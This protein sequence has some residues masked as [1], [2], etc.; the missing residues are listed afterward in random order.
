MPEIVKQYEI[1]DLSQSDINITAHEVLSEMGIQ[2]MNSKEISSKPL[3]VATEGI[4]PSAWGWGG[5]KIGYEVL[6][7]ETGTQLLLKGYIAQL[8][9][10]PLMKKMDEFLSLLSSKLSSKYN[11]TQQFEKVTS[12][13]PKMKLK[14]SDLTIILIL[15]S[16]I[17][18]GVLGELFFG[19]GSLG[20][21]VV[22]P[23]AYVI[24]SKALRK[25]QE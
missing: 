18:I 23:V 22:F 4:A 2:E 17:V 25:D 7:S 14:R 11:H 5:M 21:L 20:W 16:G 13:M 3:H 15:L 12:F 19:L 9:T 6:Q 24:G 1:S 10:T 8:G